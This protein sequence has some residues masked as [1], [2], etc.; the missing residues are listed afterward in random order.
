MLKTAFQLTRPETRTTSVVFASP[1]SGRDYPPSFLRQAV[2][3][4]QQIRSSEDAFVDQL[5][6]AAPRH[7]APLLTANAP[8][9]YLDL[10]RGPDELDSALIE[11][12]QKAVDE[13]GQ[14]KP[15]ADRL[16]AWLKSLSDGEASEDLNLQFYE[17]VLAELKVGGTD[18]AD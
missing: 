13:A 8:R 9:A 15:V 10:S 6:A 11:A 5:F 16:T 3:D 2:L 7:G 18:D 12:L 17:N 4:D 1:H 14:P